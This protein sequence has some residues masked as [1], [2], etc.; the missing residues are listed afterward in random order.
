[1]T[2]PGKPKVFRSHGKRLEL[3][4][5]I[6]SF[7]ETHIADRRVSANWNGAVAALKLFSPKALMLSAFDF[8]YGPRASLEAK[9]ALAE[10]KTI[11][12]RLDLP[13][14]A[15]LFLDS[16]GLESISHPDLE[17]TPE[18]SY[19]I[20]RKL[21]ADVITLM[22]FPRS[23]TGD[24]RA[25]VI[26]EFDVATGFA[27]L[28]D[29]SAGLAAVI[30]GRSSDE[31]VRQTT[32]LASLSV[33]KVLCVPTK[34]LGGNLEKKSETVRALK[35]V[36]LDKVL[37]ILAEGSPKAWG[38]LVA[39]GADSFDATTWC[40]A[41]ISPET[42]RQIA[43]WIPPR[44]TCNCVQCRG[45]LMEVACRSRTDMLVHNLSLFSSKMDDIREN[46]GR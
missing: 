1:M 41:L 26:D 31:L 46:V 4:A 38:D 44:T 10:H 45:E 17:F 25:P 13:Q 36:S 30:H 22:D 7:S 27:A 20:Q 33:V 5:Y 34:S 14:A 9:E 2:Q 3:P 29:G 24:T 23:R 11:S 12:E 35:A 28:H 43:H 21:G 19:A 37:H 18:M 16:G 39:A 8:L 42:F 15:L 32:R 40:R 6:P